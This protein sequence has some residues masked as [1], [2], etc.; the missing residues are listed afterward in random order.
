[1]HSQIQCNYDN[2]Y[3]LLVHK[4]DLTDSQKSELRGLINKID[5]CWKIWNKVRWDKAMNKK[6]VLELKEY[7]G[8][9][10]IPY[11]D[12]SWALAR[13]WNSRNRNTKSLVEEFYINTKNYMYNS[14]IF[15]ESGDRADLRTIFT[16]LIEKYKIKSVID[17]GC[18]VGNDGLNMIGMVQKVTFVDFNSPSQD[19]LKWRLKNRNINPEKY[20]VVNV[21]SQLPKKPSEMF[22]SIDVI[23]H[24]KNPLDIFKWINNETKLV[25]YYT[26]TDDKAG[27]RHP[28][29]FKIDKDSLNREFIK[30]NYVK[31]PHPFLNIWV[32]SFL[33]R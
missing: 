30:R 3:S 21:N 20:E 23:E 2:L 13:E 25:A 29:H 1:M 4:S 11:Y 15:F 18:G 8:N 10:F 12:S 5:D 32:K 7:L 27:G 24:M 33:D 19:F 31:K 16:Q 26:D 6:G 9:E 22:W 14:I 17:Y 28:F